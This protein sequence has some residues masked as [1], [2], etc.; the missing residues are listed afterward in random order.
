MEREYSKSDSLAAAD[1]LVDIVDMRHCT[2]NRK[3]DCLHQSVGWCIEA[4]E[5]KFGKLTN[6][7]RAGLA[8]MILS[9]VED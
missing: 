8:K 2:A 7:Q 4:L 5:L 3:T 1:N 9:S 6:S